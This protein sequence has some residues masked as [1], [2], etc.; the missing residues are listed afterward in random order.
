MKPQQLYSLLVLFSTLI[1]FVLSSGSELLAQ[2]KD[3][4]GARKSIFD[5]VT[6]ETKNEQKQTPSIQNFTP[7]VQAQNHKVTE[8][9]VLPMPSAAPELTQQ[10]ITNQS[11]LNQQN[12]LNQP[13]IQ[14]ADR[15]SSTSNIAGAVQGNN[16]I[17]VKALPPGVAKYI[18][19]GVSKILPGKAQNLRNAVMQYIPVNG[20]Q[21]QNQ[22]FGPN[23]TKASQATP[24]SAHSNHGNQQL[25]S[26]GSACAPFVPSGDPYWDER[27]RQNIRE[28]QS[29]LPQTPLPIDSFGVDSD[30]RAFAIAGLERS[31]MGP[32]R[33]RMAGCMGEY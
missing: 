33:R 31:A 24:T 27:A 4:N 14:N 21:S 6:R 10:N 15:S 2:S 5:I 3:H 7:A 22:A 16:V 11:P 25:S 9:G 28:E 18:N 20:L 32:K 19:Q 30:L 13:G 12:S 26:G 1:G 17:P 8:P 23:S 29:C